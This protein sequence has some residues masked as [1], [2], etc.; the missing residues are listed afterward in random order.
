MKPVT[1]ITPSVLARLERDRVARLR[2]AELKDAQR[3]AAEDARHRRLIDLSS[4]FFALSDLHREA[5]EACLAVPGEDQWE[6]ASDLF[7]L[8]SHTGDKLDAWFSEQIE[9]GGAT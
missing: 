3:Q 9:S 5:C 1:P 7:M 8:L 4:L 6:L 2:D